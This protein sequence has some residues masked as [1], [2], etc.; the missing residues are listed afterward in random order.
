MQVKVQHLIDEGQ[1]VCLSCGGKN[2]GIAGPAIS[3]YQIQLHLIVQTI[4]L[5]YPGVCED[6]DLN[7]KVQ[8]MGGYHESKKYSNS[9][10]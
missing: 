4:G 9:K 6:C 2:T 3:T 8:P 1:Y 10:W 7:E 5:V